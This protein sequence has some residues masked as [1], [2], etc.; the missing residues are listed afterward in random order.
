[1]AKC[2]AISPHVLDSEYCTVDN[3]GQ[4][5]PRIQTSGAK[6]GRRE[7]LQCQPVSDQNSHDDCED[8]HLSS[9]K[10]HAHAG[11][12][13]MERCG[14]SVA[15]ADALQNARNSETREVK[16]RES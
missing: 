2:G 5:P 15:D 16:V 14:D 11:E 10:A 4:A 6:F 13:D 7:I 9:A 3:G 8:P 12:C 1:M